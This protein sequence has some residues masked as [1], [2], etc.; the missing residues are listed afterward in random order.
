MKLSPEQS[1]FWVFLYWLRPQFSISSLASHAATFFLFPIY[2]VFVFRG[3]C[4]LEKPLKTR[5]CFRYPAVDF[6]ANNRVT[7]VT[8]KPNRF[9][10]NLSYCNSR[11]SYLLTPSIARSTLSLL[12]LPSGKKWVRSLSFT[13][14]YRYQLPSFPLRLPWL[15]R[16]RNLYFQRVTF[17]LHSS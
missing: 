16:L 6:P 12:Y 9:Q 7:T 8:P 1:L 11:I 3:L 10:R 13:V 2:I 15:I 17:T 14:S 5:V 4:S